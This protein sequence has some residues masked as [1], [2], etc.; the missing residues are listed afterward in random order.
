MVFNWIDQLIAGFIGKCFSSFD[1]IDV[2]KYPWEVSYPADFAVPVIPEKETI[3]SLME[4]AIDAHS[5]KVAFIDGDN[6]YS[7]SDINRRANALTH[8][9]REKGAK[10][11]D[12]IAIMMPNGIGFI[13]AV[14]ASL[15]L[16]LI[17]VLINP[18][19]SIRE[20]S[21]QIND[22]GAKWLVATSEA[23]R[24][25]GNDLIILKLD[26][27]FTDREY[28]GNFQDKV[29]NFR[30][31]C[32]SDQDENISF[33]S[34]PNDLALIQYTGGT[35]GVS[36][37]AMLTHRN[38]VSN[39]FQMEAFLR[40]AG[41]SK[42]DRIL[43][44]LPLYHIFAFAVNFL[45]FFRL[46]CSNILVSKPG[47]NGEIQKNF[48]RHKPTAITGVNTLFAS[49][50][51]SRD[52]QLEDIRLAIGGGAPVLPAV[53]NAWYSRTQSR[54]LEGYGLSETSPVVTL[55]PPWRTDFRAGIGL[56]LPLTNLV[57][58]DE[59]GRQLK[60]GQVGE[61]CVSGPQ[62]MSGYYKRPDETEKVFFGN[63]LFRT[64]DIGFMEADGQFVISDRKKD[65]ILVSG[66]NV[67]P[68]EVEN[69]ASEIPE[70]LECACVGLKDDTGIEK[71]TLFYVVR[72]GASITKDDIKNFCYDKMAAYKVPKILMQV[73]ALPKSSVGKILRRELRLNK[74]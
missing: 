41:L 13:I 53:S 15:K 74:T 69:V 49:L 23:S 8:L 32:E 26:H 48:R 67:F 17:V 72:E 55:N 1:V 27:V 14:L 43:T 6:Q 68:N 54:I 47:E 35:T 16:G 56:P 71:V 40:Y 3:L 65:M 57:V 51:N 33:N 19:Y 20:L 70:I 9:I 28:F 46:G 34:H 25:W 50:L 64:G 36:K 29:S 5:N 66:F 62:V 60:V 2:E 61:L 52:L 18:Q 7:Y 63:N 38:L 31:R 10:P 11:E 42:E 21:Y 12:R 24:T 45:Y 58:C 22:S 39:Q 73:E 59:Q 44:V 37:G 4:K 30:D